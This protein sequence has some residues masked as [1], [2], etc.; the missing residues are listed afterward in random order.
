MRQIFKTCCLRKRLQERFPQ[1][2][3]QKSHQGCKI[4]Y[5]QKSNYSFVAERAL[6][7]EDRSDLDETDED[8]E[9]NVLDDSKLRNES[10]IS[11]GE[12]SDADSLDRD[13]E[14]FEEHS[15]P[16]P[17]IA[18]TVNFVIL[19]LF[20]L[21]I[22]ISNEKL[23]LMSLILLT[24]KRLQERFPQLVF[25]KSHQ[26]C[27][28]VYAQKSNYSFV[29]ERALGAE[30]QSDLDKTDEDEE[31]NLLDDSKLR[32]ESQMVRIK[33]LYLVA[34]E[35]RNNICSNSESRYKQ[36]PPVASDISGKKV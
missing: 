8:E 22:R 4:V 32:N 9:K 35:L 1:L 16:R 2:V 19:I 14:I 10:Q 31:K 36:W 30:N 17:Q 12:L 23:K 24:R 29:A 21:Y 34:L 20:S 3:F 18:S 28:I 15:M 6:G 7:A 11:D 33:D 26:G 5:A 27:E 25:Q 13:D